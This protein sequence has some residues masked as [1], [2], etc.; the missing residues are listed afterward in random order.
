MGS[1]AWQIDA[2][3][4]GGNIL[5]DR[6]EADSA[7]VRQDM[8]D[9][10]GWWFWWQFRVREAQGRTLTF[11]HV[12]PKPNNNRYPFGR[13]GPAVSADGGLTWSWLG[14][15]SVGGADAPG[16]FTYT[17]AP[18]A[19][20]VR[21]AFAQPYV[22]ADLLR[23]LASCAGCAHLERR[24]LC[25]SRK[26]RPVHRLHAGCLSGRPDVRVLITA[27][28]HAC[29]SLA[30]FEIEGLLGSVLE[31]SDLGRW[32]QRHVEL[33]VVPF[34]DTDGVEEG[35]QG[36]NRRP[37]D[38]GRD[39]EGESLYAETRALR[40]LAPAWSEGKLRMAFDLHCPAPRDRVIQIVGSSDPGM[41]EKQCRFARVLE[42]VAAGP[43]P[44]HSA[45]DLPFGQGFNTGGNYAG[46]KSCSRWAAGL[47]DVALVVGLEFPY[48][49]AHDCEVT[50]DKAR[51]FGRDLARALRA[52]IEASPAEAGR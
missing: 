2:D 32:F 36:K 47:P 5:V 8:R 12:H 19:A 23:F 37:R 39:Y 38:H 24:E 45:D 48:A 44:Y 9:T 35:D 50:A 29:E 30:G 16:A 40:E 42:S 18:E 21:F 34:M 52:Y 11:R 28:H 7:D 51:L 31:D 4:A 17:F 1:Q 26:G 46:G 10:E 13:R 27:R 33:M 14:A 25:R 22:D 41:W 49:E 3:F 15:E 43:L 6:T 20:E